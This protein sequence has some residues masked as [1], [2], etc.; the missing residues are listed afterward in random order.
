MARRRRSRLRPA[1]VFFALALAVTPLI[2]PNGDSPVDQFVELVAE[3][4]R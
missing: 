2:W 4:V 1:L 3:V